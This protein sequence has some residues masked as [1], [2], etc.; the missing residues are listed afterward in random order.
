ML[1]RQFKNQDGNPGLSFHEHV[2][3]IT[4]S[5]SGLFQKDSFVTTGPRSRVTAYSEFLM[6]DVLRELTL[7]VNQS[8]EQHA[9]RSAVA[10]L[11][12]A[13]ELSRLRSRDHAATA[14]TL[15]SGHLLD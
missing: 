13:D 5:T 1:A 2:G 8:M 10:V 7:A 6:P 15:V 3:F 12:L 4:G 9:A 11:S 14:A